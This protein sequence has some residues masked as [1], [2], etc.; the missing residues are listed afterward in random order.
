VSLAVTQG[1]G[2]FLYEVAPEDPFIL[3]VTSAVLLLVSAVAGY[4]PARRA[5]VANPAQILRTE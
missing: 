2:S 1:L 4:V 5:M 3:G